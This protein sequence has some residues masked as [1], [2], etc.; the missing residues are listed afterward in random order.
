[1]LDAY[2]HTWQSEQC[3]TCGE[4][5][6]QVCVE[7]LCSRRL[8][9]QRGWFQVN[10]QQPSTAQNLSF[11]EAVHFLKMLQQRGRVTIQDC[12]PKRRRMPSMQ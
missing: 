11:K 12:L 3:C 7:L 8:K 5:L 9:T 2:V 6:L 4:Q 10:L 1:M